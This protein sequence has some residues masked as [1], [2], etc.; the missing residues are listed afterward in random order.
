M[1][2]H[3]GT[4]AQGPH[5]DEQRLESEIEKEINKLKYFLEEVDDLIQLKDYTEMEIVTRRAEKIID[6]LSDLISHTEELKIDGSASSRSVRQWKKDIKSRYATLIADKERLSKTL[7]NRQEEIDEEIEQWRSESKQQQ[8]QEEERRAA[9][10]H[11][12]QEEHERRIWEEKLKAELEITH[13]KLE[14]ERNARSTTAKLPKLKITSFKGTPTD[15][16]RFSNM[17]ITQVHNKPIS[18]EEK[19]GYLL[20]MVSP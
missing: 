8:Q 12:R 17:F 1:S 9:E 16:V 10:L 13:K 18:T 19:F 5:E 2:D 7:K 11:I 6:K 15:W 3:E 14:L 20:E 4:A